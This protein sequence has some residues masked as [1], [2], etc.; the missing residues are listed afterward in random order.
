M[1]NDRSKWEMAK[2]V[3]VY[4]VLVYS[5]GIVLALSHLSLSDDPS[6]IRSI[7]MFFKFCKTI[8]SLRLLSMTIN[9]KTLKEFHS[10]DS[11][12]FRRIEFYS[13]SHVFLGIIRSE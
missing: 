13:S 10:Y 3:S 1:E 2:K 12:S 5:I 9:L 11:F 4:L 6:N 7:Y 8:F